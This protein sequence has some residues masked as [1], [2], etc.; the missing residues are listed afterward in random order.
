MRYIQFYNLSTGY[1]KGSIPPRF[2]DE[3]KVP[4]EACGSDGVYHIDKY[5]R[6]YEIAK[7]AQRIGKQRKFVGYCVLEGE[8]YSRAKVISGYWPILS[9][10]AD[11]TATSAYYGM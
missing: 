9:D 3:H 1:V 10:K 4:I 6:S 7:I 5:A 2:D 11:N 8:S